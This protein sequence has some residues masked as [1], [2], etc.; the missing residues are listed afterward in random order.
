VVDG[1]TVIVNTKV[2]SQKRMEAIQG[3]IRCVSKTRFDHFVRDGV[4]RAHE[5]H[6]VIRMSMVD[7]ANQGSAPGFDQLERLPSV[8]DLP[9]FHDPRT[10]EKFVKLSF[11]FLLD[12]SGFHLRW[13]L[14]PTEGIFN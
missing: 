3:Y 10:V 7:S 9:L 2:D 6:M 13:F 12:Y 4:F 11:W 5:H 8:C 1:R 14:L